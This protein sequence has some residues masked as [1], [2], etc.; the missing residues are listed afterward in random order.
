MIL[1]TS[2]KDYRNIKLIFKNSLID[3]LKFA[4]EKVPFYSKFRDNFKN[5]NY[6][7]F[8]EFPLTYDYDLMNN[9]YSFISKDS[10]VV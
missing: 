10:R 1:L 2:I 3:Y 5:I 4:T 8:F 6:K 9:P 7:N